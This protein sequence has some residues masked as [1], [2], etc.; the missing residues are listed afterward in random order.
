VGRGQRG[1]G[2]EI[3]FQF[4]FFTFSTFNLVP[5]PMCPLWLISFLLFN[6]AIHSQTQPHN[7]IE[8]HYYF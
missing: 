7:Q 1:F 2:P 3:N 5:L 8:D 6:K 4:V